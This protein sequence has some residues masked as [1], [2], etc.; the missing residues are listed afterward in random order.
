MSTPA[1]STEPANGDHAGDGA[2]HPHVVPPSVLLGV[3][4]VLV[5]LT[6]ATVA[7]TRVDLDKFN[8]GRLNIL[9]ALAIAVVKA[10]FVV[11]YFMHLRYDSPF[12]AV[13]LISALFFVAVFLGFAIMDTGEYKPN[14]EPPGTRI[15]VTSQN[16]G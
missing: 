1:H 2:V 3:Y 16:G 6:I 9:A 5:V 12:N 14:Y 4:G 10:A 7:I 15:M 13:V 11:L 8:L